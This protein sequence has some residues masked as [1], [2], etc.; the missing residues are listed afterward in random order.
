[1]IGFGFSAGDIAMAIKFLWK[2]G[3]ALNDTGKASSEYQHAIQ[4]LQGLLLTLQHL[5]SVDLTST[6]ASIV[7]ALRTLSASVEKPIVTFI[8]DIRK[9]ESV[10]GH[11]DTRN[12]LAASWRRVRWATMNG[13]KLGK[14]SAIIA[15]QM[16]AIHV[17]LGTTILQTQ[18]KSATNHFH[19]Q[20]LLRSIAA[21]HQI[22]SDGLTHQIATVRDDT[23]TTLSRIESSQVV[24]H[25]LLLAAVQQRKVLADTLLEKIS[26]VS[27]Q[28]QDLKASQRESDFKLMS[29][30]LPQT[31]YMR[32]E[33][34]G[35]PVRYCYTETDGMA[36]RRYRDPNCS[37][38][39]S[40]CMIALALGDLLRSLLLLAPH[41]WFALGALTN[42]V[43]R[44]VSLLLDDAIHFE[45]V[46]GMERKLHYAWFQHH[47]VFEAFVR[48][49]FKSKPGEHRVRNNMYI[50]TTYDKQYVNGER[51]VTGQSSWTQSIRPGSKIRMS[52]AIIGSDETSG[53]SFSRRTDVGITAYPDCQVGRISYR[54][55]RG[56]YKRD[57]QGRTT[58]MQDFRDEDVELSAK[59]I[60][61]LRET[62]EAFAEIDHFKRV[63][64]SH[65]AETCFL[66]WSSM[67][68]L[69]TGFE[70]LY[71]GRWADFP[72]RHNRGIHRVLY[73]R[74]RSP[75]TS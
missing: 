29:T 18:V 15:A 25:E 58:I 39:Q 36:L 48:A 46:F 55:A 2:V 63:Y 5:Q 10:L 72:K 49:D 27:A 75:Y 14:L 69:S 19:N 52:L 38:I 44:S 17:L 4:Y 51:A 12:Q 1:M 28:V 9:F 23:I 37:L 13:E 50:I 33:G 22:Q 43:P 32:R 3:K 56:S 8:N 11:D 26:T 53:T 67:N 7:S 24:D 35:A 45:D 34:C 57:Q 30:L 60:T 61:A 41:L 20:A 64:S 40:L 21:E 31:T 71:N 16:Q 74:A 42:C 6:D 59:E 70:K 73:Y 66:C 65:D 54:I 47:E 62:R 68:G